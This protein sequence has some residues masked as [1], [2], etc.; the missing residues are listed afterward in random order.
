VRVLLHFK[1]LQFFKSLSEK[2]LVISEVHHQG[3]KS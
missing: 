3:E 2:L 1:Q